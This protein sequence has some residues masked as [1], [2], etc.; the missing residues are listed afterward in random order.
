MGRTRTMVVGGIVV[1]AGV[2]VLDAPAGAHVHV[3]TPLGCLDA[4]A[5][6]SGAAVAFGK[7]ADAAGPLQVVP[8]ELP[9]IPLTASGKLP[10]GGQGAASACR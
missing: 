9:V 7:A 1:A 6:S 2:L 8:G 5:A 10:S 3:F 4:D